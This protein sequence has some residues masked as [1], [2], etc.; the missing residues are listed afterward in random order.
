MALYRASVAFLGQN[1]CNVGVN[2]SHVAYG[3]AV[4]IKLLMSK[5]HRFNPDFDFDPDFDYIIDSAIL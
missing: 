2:P 1:L 3:K 4:N 5:C